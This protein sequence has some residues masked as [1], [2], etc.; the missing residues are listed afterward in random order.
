[1]LNCG[2]NGVVDKFLEMQFIKLFIAGFSIIYIDI[3]VRSF[4]KN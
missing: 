3:I 2:F 1:M 4:K